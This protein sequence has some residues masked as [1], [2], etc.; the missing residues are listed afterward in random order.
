MTECIIRGVRRVEGER[1]TI[2]AE[3]AGAYANGSLVMTDEKIAALW[4]DA[5]GRILTPPGIES[6]TAAAAPTADA[7]RVLNL[8]HYDP[9]S[10]VYRYHSA[11]NSV[12]GIVSAFV[13]WGHS[14]PHSDLRQW[15]GDADAAIVRALALTADVVHCHMDYRTLLSD[16]GRGKIDGQQ[17]A[18]TYHGSV[19]PGDTTKVWLYPETDARMD[20]VVFGARPYHQRYGDH[21]HWLPIPMPLAD[22]APLAQGHRRERRIRVAHAPTNRILKGTAIFLAAIQ[23]LQDHEGLPIEAVLIEG[24]PH[25]DALRL[26]ATCDATF[27]SFFLGMQGSGLEAAAMGQVVIAGDP[28]AQQDLLRLGIAVPWTIANDSEGL[29]AALRRLVLD[30]QWARDEAE[31]VGQYVRTYHS[32]EAVGTKYRDILTGRIRGTPHR[33]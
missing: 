14:N 23:H 7:I 24:L 28:A 13:R 20:A 12:P 1:F 15:D 5:A 18:I 22:Y 16:L 11:A 26:K 27:D 9:G 32:Y 29:R 25:A 3:A 33:Q 31:R 8:T 30:A 2:P 19:L 4:N 21:I 17:V 10:A 6:R